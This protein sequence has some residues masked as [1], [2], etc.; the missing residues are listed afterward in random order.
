VPAN[1]VISAKKVCKRYVAAVIAFPSVPVGRR[2]VDVFGAL[3]F[4]L[5]VHRAYHV[6]G[7]FL[8]PQHALI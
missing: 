4:F 5:I 7:V 6:E 8:Q 1:A 2:L 3:L